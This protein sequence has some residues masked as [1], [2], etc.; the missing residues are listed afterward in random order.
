MQSLPPASPR[1]ARSLVKLVGLDPHGC[2]GC[3]RLVDE[4]L[5]RQPWAEEPFWREVRVVTR[6]L[7]ANC[8][9][10]RTD[11]PPSR[12]V[13]PCPTCGSVETLGEKQAASSYQ[14]NCSPVGVLTPGGSA[15]FEMRLAVPAVLAPGTTRLSWALLDGRLATPTATTT[16]TCSDPPAGARSASC[17]AS[18][19]VA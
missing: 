10:D 8:Q 7:C 9:V 1:D 2:T 6:R 17:R 16:V 15:I 4:N 3:T 19:R 13:S 14:L 12:I 11:E 18:P 5:V